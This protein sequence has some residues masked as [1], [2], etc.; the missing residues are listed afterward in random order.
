M[1]EEIPTY[2]RR[3][4]KY[5]YADAMNDSGRVFIICKHYNSVSCILNPNKDKSCLVKFAVQ[6]EEKSKLIS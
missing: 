3:I 4:S 5:V 1:P 6:R 2:C